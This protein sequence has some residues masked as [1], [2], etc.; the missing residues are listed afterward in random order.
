MV[1]KKRTRKF[2]HPYVDNHCKAELPMSDHQ[3]AGFPALEVKLYLGCDK[4]KSP[5][6]SLPTSPYDARSFNR[7]MNDIL[8]INAS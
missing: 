1:D 4:K 6:S 8:C 2:P 5:K 7:F 3:I